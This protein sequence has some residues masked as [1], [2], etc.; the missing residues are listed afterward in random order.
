MDL[1]QVE[2][3]LIWAAGFFDGEGCI[4]VTKTKVSYGRKYSHTFVLHI[5]QKV[6]SP[7]FIFKQL[8]GGK[9]YKTIDNRHDKYT[10]YEWC[11]FGKQALDALSLLE[12]FLVLKKDEA[13]VALKRKDAFNGKI[14]LDD[15]NF[16]IR[17][18]LYY[19]LKRLKD[20]KYQRI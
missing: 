4:K 13:K 12:P 18:L 8:F 15:E 10:R 16:K 1:V 6:K 17:D 7:L 14:K 3:R 19:E 5:T 9:I 20:I 2:N 11:I